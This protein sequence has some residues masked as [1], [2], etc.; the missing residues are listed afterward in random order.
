M[1][2]TPKSASPASGVSP[3]S[4]RTTAA[5]L[6]VSVG[7]DMLRDLGLDHELQQAHVITVATAEAATIQNHHMMWL[8]A[9][10]NFRK[11]PSQRGTRSELRK[12]ADGSFQLSSPASNQMLSLGELPGSSTLC[13]N[14]AIPPPEVCFMATAETSVTLANRII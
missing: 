4:A 11:S 6:G 3:V 13:D 8:G 5:V 7:I 12:S 10:S 14:K 2:V 9:A 1:P